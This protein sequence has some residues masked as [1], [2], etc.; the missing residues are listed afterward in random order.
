MTA[1][2]TTSGS[3]VRLRPIA[4]TDLERVAEFLFTLSITEP[5]TDIVRLREVFEST[6]FWLETTGVTF[7]KPLALHAVWA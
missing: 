6:G 7:R 2:P 3:L 4:E 1:A 5:L